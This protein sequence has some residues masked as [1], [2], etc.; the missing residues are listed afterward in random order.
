M[1]VFGL[2]VAFLILM[3]AA[4]RTF[5]DRM[6]RKEQQEMNRIRREI[7]EATRREERR[8]ASE[9]RSAEEGTPLWATGSRSKQFSRRTRA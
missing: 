3:W 2:V 8:I 6:E 7:H 4:W 5:L 9:L 1:I